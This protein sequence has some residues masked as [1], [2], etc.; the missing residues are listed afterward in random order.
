M[1][2]N[3]A[4]DFWVENS[5]ESATDLEIVVDV[6]GFSV[7]FQTSISIGEKLLVNLSLRLSGDCALRQY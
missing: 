2:G 4:A 3:P 7:A 6:E 1:V 5:R